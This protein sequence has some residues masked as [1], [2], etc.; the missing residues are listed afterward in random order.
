MTSFIFFICALFFGGYWI[1]VKKHLVPAHPILFKLKW[2]RDHLVHPEI[3]RLMTVQIW[4]EDNSER[5]HAIW[6][7]NNEIWMPKNMFKPVDMY[8]EERYIYTPNLKKLGLRVTTHND[9]FF[10][11]AIDT[12]EVRQVIAETTFPIRMNEASFDEHGLRKTN[13][14]PG[15][16]CTQTI[17]FT[18]DSFTE[19]LWVSNEQTFVNQF[20]A[21]RQKDQATRACVVNGGVNGYGS[22]EQ[23]YTTEYFYPFYHFDVLYVMYFANDV[24]AN[25]KKVLSEEKTPEEAQEIALAWQTSFKYLKQMKQ[26]SVEKNIP[27]ILV[28]IPTKDQYHGS[29]DLERY[30]YRLKRF[31]EEENVFFYDPYEDIKE[32][33]SDKI[34]FPDDYH[35]SFDGN[36]LFAE[37]LYENT[38]Q[39]LKNA[40]IPAAS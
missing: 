17:Y 7:T 31:A 21:L 40:E 10:T 4:H 25:F 1:A 39:W 35:F 9:F 11:D 27:M 30:Q 14:P 19:G 33:G 16:G 5:F 8:G 18:G 37:M 34:F 29:S 2:T 32:V 24:H 6:D 20:A 15:P 38:K 3:Q 26:F 28:V 36:R 13:Y 12:P 23:A 22:L